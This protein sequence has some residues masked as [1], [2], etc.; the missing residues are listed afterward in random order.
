M[1]NLINVV[2]LLLSIVILGCG[3]SSIQKE[4][5]T[6]GI[7][8]GQCSF[9]NLGTAKGS[10]CGRMSVGFKHISGMMKTA[11]SAIFCSGEVEPK[12]TNI[13]KFNIP[14]MKELCYLDVPD[15]NWKE[16]CNVSTFEPKESIPAFEGKLSQLVYFRR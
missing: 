2:V 13:I 7:G 12:S 8:E 10:Q 1:K 4:C 6:N 11:K 14:N 16:F 15:W 3:K 5:T 9:T